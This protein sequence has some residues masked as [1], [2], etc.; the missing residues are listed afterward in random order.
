M[1][2][3]DAVDAAAVGSAPSVYGLTGVHV[4]FDHESEVGV[5]ATVGAGC[6]GPVRAC[7]DVPVANGD[8]RAI[9]GSCIYGSEDVTGFVD[10][11]DVVGELVHYEE[12][13]VVPLQA[14]RHFAGR[15][16]SNT[17]L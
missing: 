2:P 15:G 7:P 5:G 11:I 6:G 10:D 4:A 9:L 12:F 3:L 8:A 17:D 14:V 13:V 16:D 1:I